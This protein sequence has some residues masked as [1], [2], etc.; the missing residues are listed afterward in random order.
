MPVKAVTKKS[1]ARDL[2][3]QKEAAAFA[4]IL[5]VFGAV[6]VLE[7]F[8]IAG[9]EQ[10]LRNDYYAVGINTSCITAGTYSR[11]WRAPPRR[12]RLQ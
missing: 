11:F 3:K 1:E 5:W 6:V 12:R 4:N 9:Y 8:L 7:T 10:C 2:K